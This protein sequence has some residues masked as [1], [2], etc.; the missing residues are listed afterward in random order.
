M[1]GLPRDFTHH[2][3]LAALASLMDEE[4]DAECDHNNIPI[5]NPPST[6]NH[7]LPTVLNKGGGK[8]QRMRQRQLEQPYTTTTRRS[9]THRSS[10]NH[11]ATVGEAQL[12]LKLWNLKE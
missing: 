9:T 7:S 11:S 10:S 4:H 8:S 6:Q 3:Q 1:E 2:P 5:A 12:F